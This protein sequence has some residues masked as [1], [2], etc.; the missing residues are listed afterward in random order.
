MHYCSFVVQNQYIC[1]T[2][3]F[4]IMAT[5]K[6]FIRTGKKDG[7][8]NIRFRLSDGRTVQLFHTSEILVLS[9]LWDSKKEQYKQKVIIP[10]HC[11]SRESL[12]KEIT[13]R[14]NLILQLYSNEIIRTSEQL[15]EFIDK[16]INPENYEI[17]VESGLIVRFSGYIEQCH[18]DGIFGNARK[19]HYEV[20]C[21]ELN[22]FLVID[23]IPDVEC[24]DF[25][26][27]KI[28][29]FRDFLLNEH[30]YVNK[31]KG[32]YAGLNSR[33]I[34]IEPRNQNTV[35]TKL[36]KLQAFFNDL[37]SNNEIPISPFRKIG[38]S[39]KKVI[40]REQYDE[41]AC[42]TKT[43]FLLIQNAV[44][45]NFLQEIKDVFL[46]QCALGCRISDFQA[47]NY[48]NISIED[49]IP[50][51]HYLPQK[52]K[53]EGDTR[54]E[55]KTPLM[56]FA[57]ET[58]KKYDFNFPILRNISGE[59]G[60]NAK[61]K[62]LLKQ[63]KIDKFIAEFNEKTGKNEYRPI[64]EIASSKL[65]RKT[66]VDIM[67]K[68]QINQYVSGL[69]KE[70]SNAVNRYTSMSIKDRFALMCVAFGCNEYWVDKN[71]NIV[72]SITN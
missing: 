4:R 9:S 65:A 19:K 6:A 11:K 5:I 53:K 72:R 37:E 26:S 51:I 32:L 1:T 16:Q 69:H 68:V 10:S 39:R 54:M 42:L 35:A 47:L 60:Y 41:P 27:D 52:T 18:K 15:N 61:I 40:M 64:H 57:L 13:D 56:K 3:S 29:L 21:R 59:D 71:L 46:F 62:S 24:L 50:Y 67:N 2:D 34:P 55:I 30:L 20:L 36:K 23:N 28:V 17:K 12:Y 33:N 22:R 31:Y 48:D 45:P 58:I 25:T 8:V 14:K 63:C 49:N 43:E 38:K 44:V 7:F 70:G 66:H